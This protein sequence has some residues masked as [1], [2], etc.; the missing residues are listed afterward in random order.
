MSLTY[1][2]IAGAISYLI[3]SIPFGWIIARSRSVEIRDHGSGNIGA[4]NV[5]RVLGKPWGITV[6]VLDAL[7][8]AAAVGAGMK[9]ASYAQAAPA[10]AA[11]YAILAAAFAVIGHSFPV[12]LRFKGGKGVATSAG[13]LIAILPVAAVAILIVWLVV[14]YTTRYVSLASII[15]AGCLPIV[16]GILLLLHRTHGSVLF[17]F[18][19]AMTA[20]VIWRHRS[21]ISRLMSGREPR[22]VRK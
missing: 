9:I 17:Y 15:A 14:F 4:T 13:A 11:F 22:F 19:S 18:C 12:W 1:A 5:L 2:A 6:F 16:V 3:G 20:L 7:K 21:N 8:G 10:Y